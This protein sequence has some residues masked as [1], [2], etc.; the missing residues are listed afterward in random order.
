LRPSAL[1]QR[2]GSPEGSQ[3][4]LDMGG[5]LPQHLAEEDMP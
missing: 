2:R 1:R 3:K 4:V 5:I